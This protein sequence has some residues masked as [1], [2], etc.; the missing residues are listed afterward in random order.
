MT[1]RVIEGHIQSLDESKNFTEMY[2]VKLKNPLKSFRLYCS[3]SYG[4][5][6]ITNVNVFEGFHLK[7]S[8]FHIKVLKDL[9]F[10]SSDSIFFLLGLYFFRQLI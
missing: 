2:R 8:T 1:S 5:R 6:N 7:I 10:V 3:Y 4:N 9:L